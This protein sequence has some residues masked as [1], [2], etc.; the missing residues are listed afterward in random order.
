[1]TKQHAPFPTEFQEQVA[2]MNWCNIHPDRRLRLV[3]AHAN[4]A[5]MSIGAAVKLKQ[6]GAKKG[7]PDL[8]LPVG[9]GGYFGLYIEMK[10]V[11]DGVVSPEQ[12]RWIA[13]LNEQGYFATVCKGCDEAIDVISNYLGGK[14]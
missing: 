13:L 14:V 6:S 8:F 4:G 3:Y 1:M 5:R 12:R 11:K 10:R 2:L 9:N 7:I